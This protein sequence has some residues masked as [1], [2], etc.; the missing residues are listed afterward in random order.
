MCTLAAMLATKSTNSHFQNGDKSMRQKGKLLVLMAL[1]YLVSV[2]LRAQL[3]VAQHYLDNPQL[4]GEARLKVM[5]WNVFDASLYTQTG[6]YDA[7]APFSL[8]LR[9]LRRLDGD[10]IVDKSMEQI[11]ENVN[12]ND[13]DRLASWEKQLQQIIPDVTKGSTIT[14]VRTR[15]AHTRFYF[16]DKYIGQIQDAAFTKAFFDIWLGENTSQPKLRKGLIG[17]QSASL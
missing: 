5:L 15:E 4:V 3:S 16:G 7:N 8:S 6:T 12:G 1:L 17:A 14:G 10:K 11:R 13:T 9:Y 2:P